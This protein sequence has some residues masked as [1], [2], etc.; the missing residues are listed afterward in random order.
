L[1]VDAELAHDQRMYPSSAIA[2]HL[3]KG[4]DNGTIADYHLAESGTDYYVLNFL[5]FAWHRVGW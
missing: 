3:K 1:R 5:A 4:D 2:E